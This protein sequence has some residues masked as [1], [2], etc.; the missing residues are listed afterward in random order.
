MR[1]RKGLVPGIFSLDQ[2]Q[3]LSG[4]KKQVR[5]SS[6][7]AL[8]QQPMALIALI[9]AIE[10]GDDAKVVELWNP[11]VQFVA[12]AGQIPNNA[13]TQSQRAKLHKIF[14]VRF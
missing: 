13:L 8:Q 10:K 6:P 5:E 1:K 3:Q 7:A 9:N 14:G 4:T 12:N 11:I 2:W